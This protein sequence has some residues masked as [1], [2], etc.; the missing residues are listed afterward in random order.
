MLKC[1]DKEN[2]AVH[3]DFYGKASPVK[4]AAADGDITG[5]IMPRAD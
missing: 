5:I 2:E 1:L 3:F 4:I